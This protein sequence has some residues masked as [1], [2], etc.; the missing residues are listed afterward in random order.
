M[1]LIKYIGIKDFEYDIQGL[2][3]S[4]FPGEKMVTD[5]ET[6]ARLT[7][8]TDICEENISLMLEE[9]S[10]IIDKAS[11]EICREDRKDT[12][13]R[14]KRLVYELLSSYT[15]KTLPWGTLSGIRPTKIT[16]ALL[17]EG[18][19]VPWIKQYME[20]E[21]YLS[22]EKTQLSIGISQRELKIL[23]SIDYENGYSIYI[24]IPFCP[25]TCSY[26]S[27]TSY[28][29]AAYKDKVDA[30]I[31]ALC[32]EIHFVGERFREKKL[33]TI[34]IGGGTPTT[35]E[36]YQMERLLGEIEN[37]F[38]LSYVREF[39]VE[40]G[41]PDSITPD[42]LKIMVE[43]N[44]TRISVNPQTMNEK[45]LKLIG[46]NHTVEQ[47]HEAFGMA[48]SAGFDNINMDFIVGLPQESIEDVRYTMEE[49]K[50][51]H[52]DSIT[53]HS[54]AVKRA[55]KLN[56]QKEEF[57]E[58]SYV[59]DSA[60]MN[61]TA[62]YAQ[63]MG[64]Q[65]YYLYRQK[66]MTGNMENVGYAVPDKAGIYNILIMEEKQSIVALGAGA[67]SKMVF[68][69]EKF[70]QEIFPVGKFPMG[71]KIHRI[72]NVKDVDCYISRINEMIGRKAKFLD[73]YGQIL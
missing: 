39:T 28:P 15:G 58:Y 68:S 44:V 50:K 60:I 1:I 23:E 30:Y 49:V 55:A 54:L 62:K 29:L 65:P 41:R 70:S 66:N 5:K 45:T 12:K 67:A 27:F 57:E 11:C 37:T 51:I 71:K 36:P 9:Q 4:F 24:G 63:E 10:D 47:I 8:I 32:R 42:K 25:S 53:I 38:D 59:N 43:H 13:N 69:A 6:S 14:L 73:K 35:L 61:M 72:E 46:R 33:N 52:P 21:Y 19:N 20:S 56:T 64:M 40:A 22:D 16:T 34:Y 26:C 31:D 18:K 3:R 17:K 2:I 48:R 7:L